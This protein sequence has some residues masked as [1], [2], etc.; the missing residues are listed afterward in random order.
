MLPPI[1]INTFRDLT[2]MLRLTRDLPAFLQAPLSIEQAESMI[3]KR[4]EFRVE[5]LL[6]V[7]EQNIYGNPRSPYLKLLQIAGCEFGDFR[8]LVAQEG[9]EGALSKLAE[10][11]VYVTYDE[12]KGR[13]EIVR[14]SQRFKVSDEDFDNPVV[15]PHFEI[16]SGGSRGDA[17]SVKVSLPFIQDMAANLAVAL[18]SQRLDGYEHAYWLLSTAMTLSLRAAKIGRPP[19]AWFYPTHPLSAKLRIS[20][21]WLSLVSRMA[22][23]PLP[24]PVFLELQR[25]DKMAQWLFKRVE[26]G[27]GICLTCYASSAVRICTAATEMGLSLNGICFYAFGEP[28]TD[29]KR[30]IIEAAG[31]RVVVHYGF[32]EG[33]F[34]GFSCGNSQVADDVHFFRDA[35]ALIQQ[36][37]AVGDS[38]IVVQAFLLT[39]L[40]TSTPKIMLNMDLGDH[41]VFSQRRCGCHFETYGLTQHITHIRSYEKLS[42]E[43]MTFVRT[44]ILKILE[45]I[46][47][48]RF[49]GT[50]M[51]YQLVEEEDK[52]GILRLYMMV[53]PAIGPVDASALRQAFLDELAKKGGYAPLG[54]DIWW[55]AKTLEIKRQAPIATKAGKILP[56][57]LIKG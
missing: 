24:S 40:L 25:P 22:G 49:G 12:F 13:K 32:T 50:M 36:P 30:A 44:D 57:H 26:E 53:D 9:I 23:V 29:V 37:R 54:V 21:R 43:G 1:L 34:L 39:N 18:H 3:R 2:M 41:G 5:R 11:G 6:A 33:G 52:Q 38:G 28:V 31:A 45:E 35:Y 14:G 15:C 47:P 46:L 20:S 16:R 19:L 48:K 42:S 17:T 7:V 27:K 4:L 55:R 56:F 51:D 10:T 8:S